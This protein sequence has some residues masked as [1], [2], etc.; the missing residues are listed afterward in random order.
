VLRLAPP[1]DDAAKAREVI[2]RQTKQMSRL[3]DDL[4]DVSRITL[5]KASLHPEPVELSALVRDAMRTVEQAGKLA[6]H[7]VETDLAPAWVNGDRARL[8]QVVV[9]LLDNAIKFTP[10]GRRILVSVKENHGVATLAI[11]DAGIGIPAGELTRVFD[12]FIQGPQDMSRVRGGMGVGLAI[13]K[14]LVELHGGQ[15]TAASAGPGTGSTFTV[16][17]ASISEPGATPSPRPEPPI[18]SRPLDVLVV[19]DNADT[20]ESLLALL[21][22]KGHRVKGAADGHAALESIAQSR[23]DLAFVDIG[24]PDLDGY[25]IARHVRTLPGTTSIVLVALTGY[26]QPEDEARAFSAGF[27]LHVTKPIAVDHLDRVLGEFQS[28]AGREAGGPGQGVSNA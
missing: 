19:E 1:G 18:L 9:N 3:V 21:E 26:G 6:H 12:L 14:R 7:D 25:A 28:R 11:S 2:V 4:L 24:L 5:G 10:A 15:V 27:D 20:R 22:L 8:E 16:T 13:V 17:L 23:P